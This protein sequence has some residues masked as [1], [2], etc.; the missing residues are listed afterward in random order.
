MADWI[1]GPEATIVASLVAALFAAAQVCVAR[2]LKNIAYDKLKLALFEKY[3]AIYSAAKKL[4]EGIRG[5]RG[6]RIEDANFFLQHYITLDEARFFFDCEM[7]SFLRNIME[8]C[9]AYIIAVE[10]NDNSGASEHKKKLNAIYDELPTRFQNALEI[11]ALKSPK[12]LLLRR[13]T[14]NLAR[15]SGK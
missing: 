12:R 11:K 3:Y 8:V 6:S 4:I 15:K 10:Q 5:G 13:C 9:E 1:T 14:A 7:Q 2:A